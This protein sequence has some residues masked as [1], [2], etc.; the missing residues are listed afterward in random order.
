MNF[1]EIKP[2]SITLS[3]SGTLIDPCQSQASSP[4]SELQSKLQCCADFF[5]LGKALQVAGSQGHTAPAIW[6]A[7]NYFIKLAAPSSSHETNPQKQQEIS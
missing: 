2:V 4:G 7:A 6:Q 5:Q 3:N 1:A